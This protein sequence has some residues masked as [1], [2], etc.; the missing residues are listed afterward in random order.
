MSFNRGAVSAQQ[1]AREFQ[2]RRPE[3]VG[4]RAYTWL[5]RGLHEALLMFIGQ[6]KGAATGRRE[7]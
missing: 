7:R 3:A 1:Y 5:S 2:N 6:A 4:E